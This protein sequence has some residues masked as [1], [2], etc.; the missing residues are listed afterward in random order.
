MVRVDGPGSVALSGGEVFVASRNSLVRIDERGRRQSAT[1][2]I[3]NPGQLATT[4]A[5]LV[6]MGDEPTNRVWVLDH[7]GRT[8]GRLVGAADESS[9]L[10]QPRGLA[11]SADNRLYAVNENHATVYDL[12]ERR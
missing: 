11:V 6:L 2:L 3:G 8:I 12:P 1:R 5:G 9:S 7:D 4:P 10:G